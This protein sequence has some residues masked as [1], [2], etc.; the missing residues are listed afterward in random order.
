MAENLNVVTEDLVTFAQR[1]T[2]PNPRV[3]TPG[4]AMP[5]MCGMGES[6][7]LWM[8]GD[9]LVADGV[10]CLGKVDAG[11]QGYKAKVLECHD[12]ILTTDGRNT[13]AI[14]SSFQGGGA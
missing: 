6:S 7:Y 4:D 2:N 14:L 13:A 5:G 9:K 12:D 1:L 8:A 11:F 3:A 10:A